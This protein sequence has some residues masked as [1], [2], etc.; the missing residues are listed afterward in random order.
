MITSVLGRGRRSYLFFKNEVRRSVIRERISGIRKSQSHSDRF[1]SLQG[2]ITHRLNAVIDTQSNQNNLSNLREELRYFSHELFKGLVHHKIRQS[3]N[4]TIFYPDFSYKLFILS[5]R[6]EPLNPNIFTMV[7]GFFVTL[8]LLRLENSIKSFIASLFVVLIT[9]IIHNLQYYYWKFKRP[10]RLSSLFAFDILNLLALIA[11]FSILKSNFGFYKLVSNEPFLF[12][13]LVILYSFFFVLGHISRISDIAKMSMDV[14]REEVLNNAPSQSELVENEEYRIRL[15]YSKFIHSVLQPYLLVMQL[16]NNPPS[17]DF[18]ILEIK[19]MVLNFKDSLLFF[20]DPEILTLDDCFTSL[21]RKWDG[22][23]SIIQTT[24]SI[25]SATKISPQAILDLRDVLSELAVNAVK[26][27][28]AD[29]LR[30]DVKSKEGSSLVVRAENNGTLLSKIK[31]GLGLSVFDL[32]CGDNWSLK[33][34][35]GMVVFTCR[36]FNQ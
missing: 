33:N 15:E 1:N 29:L 3:K 32:L 18:Q 11:V 5:I 14:V 35:N 2:E 13:M 8:P 25:S 36:I 27:G 20:G 31:P 9:F 23:I 34:N 6:N 28:G 16:S 24:E 22:V 17:K 10:V 21:N 7:I 30:V 12:I 19:R 4:N 26:H